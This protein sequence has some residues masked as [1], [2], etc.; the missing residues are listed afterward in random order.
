MFDEEHI[1]YGEPGNAEKRPARRIL[2]VDDHRDS[3]ESLVELLQLQGHDVRGV[4]VAKEAFWEA[5]RF[6]PDLIFLDIR[7]PG[8]SGHEVCRRIR[9]EPWGKSIVIIALT[10]F[11]QEVDRR[12]TEESGFND[13]LVKPVAPAALLH[14]LNSL[15]AKIER[16]QEKREG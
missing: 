12:R 9:K 4:Y 1:G 2:V 14:V 5:G 7:M 11:G 3:G 16:R 6:L 8:L 10:A 15:S 13:H